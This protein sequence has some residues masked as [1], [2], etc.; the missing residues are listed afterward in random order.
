MTS[1]ARRLAVAAVAL[2]AAAT[3]VA[4]AP[5]ALAAAPTHVGIVVRFADGNVSTACTTVGGSGYTVLSRKFQ[6]HI[7]TSGPYAGFLLQISQLPN[8]ANPDT[9]H[10]WSYWH[11]KSGGGWTY[12]STGAGSYTPKAGGIEG[13]SYV[14]GQSTAP[15]PPNYTYAA[16]CASSDGRPKPTATPAPKSS[17]KSVVHVTY[18][19]THPARA[20][21]AGTP[22]RHSSTA[23]T[24]ATTTARSTAKPTRSATAST[25]VAVSSSPPSSSAMVSTA[26]PSASLTPAPS[27]AASTKQ[28]SSGFPAWGT[29]VALLVVLALGGGAWLATKRRPE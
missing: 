7:G 13:W 11:P 19:A 26:A 17:T 20:S 25:R 23:A 9:T 6:T 14:N 5:P 16:L 3:V 4:P 10:Y 1:R 21:T 12:S 18:A 8:P 22:P 29:I 28:A 15:P 27:A 24:A 2:A